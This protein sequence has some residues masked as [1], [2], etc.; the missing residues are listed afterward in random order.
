MIWNRIPIIKS[1]FGANDRAAAEVSLRWQ[2]AVTRDPKLAEDL[3]NL[4]GL[5]ASQPVE[6]SDGYP[7]PATIDPYRLAYEAGRADLARQLLAQGH[8]S[9]FEIN[10]LMETS[11]AH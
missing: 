1:F 10:Q 3:I 11:D 9:T 7:Q 6:M 5:M 2:K 4:G 8:I